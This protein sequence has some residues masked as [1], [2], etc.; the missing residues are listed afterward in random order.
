MRK[1]STF[2]LIFIVLVSTFF[3]NFEKVYA[4]TD[5]NMDVEVGFEN[6]VRIGDIPIIINIENN[7]KDIS[8]KIV[9]EMIKPSKKYTIIQKDIELPKA[10]TKKIVMYVPLETISKNIN[11]SLEEDDKKIKEIKHSIKKILN[12]QNPVVG[13]ISDDNNGYDYI[14]DSSLPS[15][16]SNDSVNYSWKMGYETGQIFETKTIFLDEDHIFESKLGFDGIDVI[17]LNNYDTSKLS[18]EQLNSIDKWIRDG[19]VLVIGTGVNINKIYSNINEEYKLISSGNVS[20]IEDDIDVKGILSTDENPLKGINVNDGDVNNAEITLKHEKTPLIVHKDIE[21]GAVVEVAFDLTDKA[22]SNWEDNKYLFKAIVEDE[23]ES[24]KNNDLNYGGS[25]YYE[26]YL[27]NIIPE[28]EGINFYFVIIILLIYIILVGPVLYLILRKL[29]IQAKNWYILPIISVISMLIIYLVGFKTKIKYPV[30]SEVSTVEFFDDNYAAID[31]SLTIFNNKSG[32]LTLEYNKDLEI[33]LNDD[34]FYDYSQTQETDDEGTFLENKITIAG[35]KLKNEIYD[36]GLW[37]ESRIIT[38]ENIETKGNIDNVLNYNNN[39]LNIDITN[40]TGLELND[41]FL[42]MGNEIIEIGN[43]KN[44]D[45]KNIVKSLEKES[46]N[47]DKYIELNYGNLDDLYMNNRLSSKEKNKI[48]IGSLIMNEVYPIIENRQNSFSEAYFISL[49]YDSLKNNIDVNGGEQKVYNT[50]IIL[51]KMNINYEKGQQIDIPKGYIKPVINVED[52]P[53]LEYMIEGN[54]IYLDSSIKTVESSFNLIDNF[55]VNSFEIDWEYGSDYQ[56]IENF[57]NEIYIYNNNSGKWDKYKRNKEIK[58]IN[59]Y[60]NDN[61]SIKVKI[62]IDD[63]NKLQDV[64][65][66]L[67]EISLKGVTK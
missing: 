28:D 59:E 39:E 56:N 32:N 49:N 40:N 7:Y 12:P 34:E 13:I 23:Y 20:K 27:T 61:N 15:V 43:L 60:I 57:E 64:Y 26:D 41:S 30:V 19:G 2:V 63:S 48:K 47:I 17:V 16:Y 11:I 31:S 10:S 8:G 22:F 3:V 33:I 51:K 5:I 35:D 18:K 38:S 6:E 52:N 1:Y 21:N 42:V 55:R 58:D 65:L 45:N 24:V 4:K 50:N 46:I 67:P 14:S 37:D 62:E 54:Y 66:L 25:F 44:S 53:N 29:D 9:I 36:V